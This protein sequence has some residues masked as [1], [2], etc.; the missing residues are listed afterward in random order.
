[1]A[2][3]FRKLYFQWGFYKNM[4][5][6]KRLPYYQMSPSSLPFTTSTWKARIGS[7]GCV[8]IDTLQTISYAMLAPGEAPPSPPPRPTIEQI[9]AEAAFQRLLAAQPKA[10]PK[11]T[12]KPEEADAENHDKIPE[13]DLQ[14]V[15]AAMDKIGW[16][17]AA[18][19]A[20]AWFAS[21]KHIYN[22]DSNSEQPID[23]TTITLKWTLKFGSVRKKYDDLIIK[24]STPPAQPRKPKGKLPS[25]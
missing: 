25:T 23:D 9:E 10:S 11:P 16:P 4:P 1:M 15:P 17:V 18:K 20:R 5:K 14:D 21:P 19:I 22:D 24:K 2:N 8:P 3:R 12:A 7:Q 13:F 6:A